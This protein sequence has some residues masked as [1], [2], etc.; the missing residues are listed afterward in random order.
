MSPD[1]SSRSP[2]PAA[3][4]ASVTRRPDDHLAT[5]VAALGGPR[6]T[7]DALGTVLLDAPTGAVAARVVRVERGRALV[8][9][10]RRLPVTTATTPVAVSPAGT[11]AVGDW[12]VVSPGPDGRAGTVEAAVERRNALVRHA[13]GPRSVAQVLVA[14]VDTVA[15]VAALDRRLPARQIERML[16]LVWD[17]G[18]RPVLV[19]TK[20]DLV[21]AATLRASR[22]E[23]V[24]L[25]LGLDVLA[26]SAFGGDGNGHGDGHGNGHGDGD[27]AADLAALVPGGTTL[28]LL[29]SSGAG[30]STLANLLLAAGGADTLLRTGEVRDSDARGRHTTTWRELVGIPGGGALVDTP[31]LR[32]VGL[33][34]SGDGV[35]TVFADVAELVGTCRFADCRHEGE[36]GCAVAGAVA[37]GEVSAER[38]AGWRALQREAAYQ[39]GRNDHR[40]RAEA[41]KVWKQRSRDS[42]GRNRP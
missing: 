25:A 5:A 31:G 1:P 20:T 8:L 11:L 36:P 34:T 23:A 9:P 14:D 17:S 7:A 35:D 22:A 2:H 29:G 32:S 6:R 19:L 16:A 12:C 4:Q 15:I 37:A 40:V 13:A 10:V 21:D 39:A 41:L 18:A 26:V 28:A 24:D 30:K 33:W 27:A 42:R 38:V 3:H